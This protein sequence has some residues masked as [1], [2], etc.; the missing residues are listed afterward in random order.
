MKVLLIIPKI[1]IPEVIPFPSNGLLYIAAV[2]EKEG[3]QVKVVD[4]YADRDYKRKITESLSE[5][6]LV[7][8]TANIAT[9]HHAVD[10]VRFIREKSP[11][12]RIVMGGPHPTS[13]YEHLIPKYADI[14]VLGEGEYTIREIVKN[15]DL[16]K[17]EGIAYYDNGL[18]VNKRRAL[19]ENLDELPHPALQ[20]I[21]LKF[22]R[23][24]KFFKTTRAVISTSR[25]C[26]YRCFH[27]TKTVHGYKIRLRSVGNVIEELDCL[28]NKFGVKVVEIMDDNFTFYPERIKELCRQI[29][30]N[31]IH[32]KISFYLLNGIRGD[33]YDEEMFSLM[34]RANFLGVVVGIETG[35]PELQE[36]IGHKLDL[37]LAKKTIAKL[38]ESGIRVSLFCIIGFPFDTKETMLQ[39]IDFAKKSTPGATY[40]FMATPFPGTEMYDLIKKKGRFLQNPIWGTEGYFSNKPR[41]EMEGLKWQDV[42][43]M[44]YR[45]YFSY[46]FNFKKI[47]EL[48]RSYAQS[49]ALR[50]N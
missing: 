3:C 17:I 18:K 7:G 8:I 49:H 23:T 31:G 45:A 25:G 26:P 50:K 44:Y 32:K 10:I 47:K 13:I 16:S 39:T 9:I 40:F 38:R 24:G 11:K 12:T 19:I 6:P 20:H 35:S 4:C 29:I 48:L 37:E 21:N 5:Y 30:K 34:R 15:I 41:F 1:R 42:K 27:C 33:I 36:K 22:Y 43:K 2:L 14:V 46:Y 28:V